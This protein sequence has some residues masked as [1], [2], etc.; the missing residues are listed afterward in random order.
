MRARATAAA[1]SQEQAQVSLVP[2]PTHTQDKTVYTQSE[3]DALKAVDPHSIRTYAEFWPFYLSQHSMSATRTL[4]MIGTSLALVLGAA[5]LAAKSWLA[6]PVGLVCGYGFAWFAHFFIE[7]NKPATFTHP[8]WSFISD[9][10]ML[11]RVVTGRLRIVGRAARERPE[12]DL[13]H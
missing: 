2:D 12:A 7:K 9:F 3:L 4:H 8:W 5:L 11:G 10:R 13:Q 6:L 1:P